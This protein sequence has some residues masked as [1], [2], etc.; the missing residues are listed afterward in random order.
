MENSSYQIPNNEKSF[1]LRFLLNYRIYKVFR[2][3]YSIGLMTRHFNFDE[4]FLNLKNL[5]IFSNSLENT[6]NTNEK[7]TRICDEVFSILMFF[8]RLP[9][10]SLSEKAIFALGLI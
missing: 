9:M 3:L 2:Q 5:K 10:L 4:I 6:L 7:K 8:S 1:V